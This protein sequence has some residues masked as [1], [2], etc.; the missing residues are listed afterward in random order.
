MNQAA[1]N[2]KGQVAAILVGTDFDVVDALEAMNVYPAGATRAARIEAAI[3]G[4]QVQRCPTCDTWVWNTDIQWN[5]HKGCC[6]V[7]AELDG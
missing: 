5:P 7:C 4:S 2:L 3:L 1:V 6:T